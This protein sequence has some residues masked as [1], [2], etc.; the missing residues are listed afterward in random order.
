MART[1]RL[2]ERQLALLRRICD[3]GTPVTSAD[4]TLA[5]TVYALRNRGL[6]ALTRK[7]GRWT[8]HPTTAGSQ[9]LALADGH[10]TEPGPPSPDTPARADTIPAT[11]EAADLMANL[12]HAGDVL[13]ITNPAPD[14]RARLRRALHAAKAQHL[15]PKDHHVQYTGRD[16]GD[17]VI[18]LLPGSH[19]TQTIPRPT[20]VH[21]DP[22]V[23]LEQLHPAVRDAP[24]AVCTDCQHRARHLLNALAHESQHRGYTLSPATSDTNASLEITAYDSTFPLR[25]SESTAEHL[26]P[27]SV[28]YSWQRVTARITRPS[29]GLDLLLPSPPW[30][31][32]GGRHRWGDRQRW[33]L[34]DKLHQ[35]LDEIEHRAKA[36][37]EQSLKQQRKEEQTRH[38]WQEAMEQA[39]IDLLKD[40]RVKA[41]REQT[42]AW[43]E[44]GRIRA[45]C[46]AL[47]QHV[48]TALAGS[49]EEQRSVMEWITWA[50]NYAD[51]IDPVH[52]RP[53]IPKDPPVRPEDLR[54]Y[55]KGWSPHGPKR[56]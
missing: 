40:F 54:P 43:H 19:P 50:R 20:P 26:D 27:D 36:E 48:S 11:N 6:V 49:P 17:L 4:S 37:H 29:H 30:G 46:D 55:L 56:A 21:F 28:Q 53:C 32:R 34:E 47:D 51:D 42:D 31:H 41:L 14:E 35:I 13:R 15:V 22:E 8:A 39:R 12:Q 3:D 52:R 25:F 5:T 1:K 10:P 23:S 44:A 24:L 18:E 16:T 2:N 45:Y 7:D 38:R 33:R 9:H